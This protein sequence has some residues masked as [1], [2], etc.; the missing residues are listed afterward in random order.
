[1]GFSLKIS[2]K[3]QNNP[4]LPVLDASARHL[5]ELCL[6]EKIEIEE[7]EMAVAAEPTLAARCLHVANSP[8][9]ASETPIETVSD[10]LLRIGMEEIKHLVLCI[11]LNEACLHFKNARDHS[12]MSWKDYWFHSLLTARLS[13]ILGNA[14]HLQL[15]G[16]EYLAGLLHDIGKVFL[17][18]YF[19]VEYRQC[20]Q[21]SIAKKIPTHEAESQLLGCHHAEIGWMLCKKWN[22]FD[23]ICHAIRHHHQSLRDWKTYAN[24]PIEARELSFC[25]FAG[26]TLTKSN[27]SDEK[28]IVDKDL[29][30]HLPPGSRQ[31][32]PLTIP[33]KKERQKTMSIVLATL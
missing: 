25:V 13:A 1:M 29:W 4:E 24:V 9:F 28:I 32:Q 14:L 26:N 16:Q 17:L 23:P 20:Q 5:V 19:P 11:S 30:K 7:L 6:K 15:P 18:H 10:A 21:L 31:P 8:A 2:D 27:E 3:I 33:I 12:F 22:I